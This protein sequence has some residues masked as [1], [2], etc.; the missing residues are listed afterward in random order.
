MSTPPHVSDFIRSSFRSV[1]ALE[2]LL[3]LKRT[4]ERAWGTEQLVEAMRGS[5]MIVDQSLDGLMRMGLVSIDAEGCARFQPATADL[6]RLAEETEALYARKP[7]TVRRIIVS[8]SHKGLATFA[9]AF[10][11]WKD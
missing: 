7:E 4:H 3:H 9:D 8:G 2:L 10:R 11:L 6:A 5:A 1:W